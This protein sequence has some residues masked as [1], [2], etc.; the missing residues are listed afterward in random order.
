MRLGTLA[1]WLEDWTLVVSSDLVRSGPVLL[2][3]AQKR[4]PLTPRMQRMLWEVRRRALAL[5][6]CFHRAARLSRGPGPDSRKWDA[7]GRVPPEIIQQIA[8]LGKISIVARD[9]V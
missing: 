3:A 8:T 9:F 1:L 4:A 7:M 2:F 5:A 6:G